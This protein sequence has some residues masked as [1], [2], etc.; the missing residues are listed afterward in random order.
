MDCFRPWTFDVDDVLDE[1]VKETLGNGVNPILGKITFMLR[2]D[3]VA[4]LLQ[5][6]ATSPQQ[7]SAFAASL[8]SMH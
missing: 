7:K 3:V 4:K 1:F 6:S 8:G 2:D 5:S